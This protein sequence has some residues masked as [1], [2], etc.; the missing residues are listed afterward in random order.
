MRAGRNAGIAKTDQP[1]VADGSSQQVILVDNED[2]QIGQD[3]KLHAHENGARLHRAFSIF[4][5]NRKGETLLQQRAMTK[6]HSQ[7]K[8]TNACCSHPMPGESVEEAAHRRLKEEMGFD[9]GLREVF[10]FTYRAEVGNG[11]TEHEYDHVLFG[12][13]DGPVLPDR[14]EAMDYKWVS[15]KRLQE[16][17]RKGPDRFTPWL[18]AS[19]DNVISAYR[20]P[21]VKE[22]KAS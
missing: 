14:E 1:A 15:L 18:R 6:Y 21:K 22:A 12:R 7:G 11:L 17:V 5:F 13:Y 4:V 8:W 10:S 20:S 3:E 16:D 9:C 19:L 2:R